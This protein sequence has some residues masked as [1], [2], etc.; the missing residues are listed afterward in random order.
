MALKIEEKFEKYW[1][2]IHNILFVA[3]VLDPMYKM[4]LIKYHFSRSFGSE[5]SNHE[6]NRVRG[7]C[8]DLVKEYQT[9]CHMN[10][11]NNQYSF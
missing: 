4:K 6:I 9:K 11:E 2:V 5:C 7:I 3:I 10:E 8:F 1:D